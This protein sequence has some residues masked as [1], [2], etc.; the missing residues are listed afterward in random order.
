MAVGERK[1]SLYKHKQAGE[2]IVTMTK[3]CEQYDINKSSLY[4]VLRGSKW[5]GRKVSA[6]KLESAKST[7]RVTPIK[8][9]E[10][11]ETPQGKGCDK[12]SS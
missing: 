9:E 10:E 4:D 7:R 5:Q 8:L 6:P 3:L 1:F 12:K 11:E 2:P